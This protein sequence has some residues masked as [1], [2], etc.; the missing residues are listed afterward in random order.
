M[1]ITCLG[2]APASTQRPRGPSGPASDCRGSPRTGHAVVPGRRVAP[3][4]RCRPLP[5][6]RQAV[7]LE[8]HPGQVAHVG[9]VVHDEDRGGLLTERCRHGW[10]PYS[11][12][13]TR[14]GLI[15][16]PAIEALAGQRGELDLG[17]VEP[18]PVLGCVV[19]LESLAQRGGLGGLEGI[20]ERGDVVNVEVCRARRGGRLE[21]S[22]VRAGAGRRRG[23]PR[24]A[25]TPSGRAWSAG[26][27]AHQRPAYAARGRRPR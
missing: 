13:A 9:L 1:I 24:R 23:G 18:P 5:R 3:G 6:G 12:C 19:D 25:S 4:P 17:D 21:P 26:A 8:E 15:A 10:D 22:G 7:D 27:R 16:D 20:L 11:G 14:Q 2:V